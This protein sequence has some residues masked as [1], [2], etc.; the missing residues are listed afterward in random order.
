MV[1]AARGTSDNAARYGQYLFGAEAGLEVGLAAPWL[2]GAGRRPPRLTGAAVIAISQ[3]G[4]SPDVAGVLAA[5]REQGRPAIAITNDPGSPLADRA[6]VVVELG[7]G[8][9]RSVAA[10]K[11]Y[12]GSLQALALIAAELAPHRVSR[13]RLARIGEVVADLAAE[14]LETRERF[15]PLAGCRLLTAVGR[16]LDYATACESALKLRELSGIAAEGFSPPDLIHGP[17]GALGPETGVWIVAS[18]R[19][20]DAD[21]RAMLARIRE[22]AGM[23]VAVSAQRG[24]RDGAAIG[25]GLPAGLPDWLGAFCAVVPAQAAGLRLAELRG[26]DVDRPNGLTKVTLTR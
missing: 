5:A 20:P 6:N 9:E 14:Q 26:V 12:L 7:V 16:G 8:A 22:R 15:D 2:F 4:R 19:E 21:A 18:S 17:L 3:S 13:D 11:T 1:I 24:V 10:T 25:V 23:A